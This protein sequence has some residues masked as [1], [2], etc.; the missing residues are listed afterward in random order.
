MHPTD[1]DMPA[2]PLVDLM[3]HSMCR[4]WHGIR[5]WPPAACDEPSTEQLGEATGNQA[6]IGG[7]KVTTD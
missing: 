7:L 5:Q 4:V 6:S 1:G 3:H 2:S